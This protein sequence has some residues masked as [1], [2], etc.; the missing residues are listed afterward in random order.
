MLESV[1]SQILRGIVGKILGGGTA[2]GSAVAVK[3]YGGDGVNFTPQALK[4]IAKLESLGFGELPVCIAK[5]QY[6]FSDDMTKL[7]APEGFKI[8]VRSLKVSAGAG[9]SSVPAGRGCRYGEC[10]VQS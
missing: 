9:H 7:G 1:C 8:T 4:E 2:A 5:T 6:S 3:V 10:V